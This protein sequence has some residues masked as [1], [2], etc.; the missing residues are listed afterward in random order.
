MSQ[1][2]AIIG[3]AGGGK[4]L[5]VPRKE[6]AAG[7]AKLAHCRQIIQVI[8]LVDRELRPRWLALLRTYEGQ[9]Q[10]TVIRRK[11]ALSTYL[12]RHSSSQTI[13]KGL[14]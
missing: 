10:I 5:F 2:I 8:Q 14:Y 1:R 7:R 4:T 3:N 11:Q 9:K 13:Q 6:V 12:A